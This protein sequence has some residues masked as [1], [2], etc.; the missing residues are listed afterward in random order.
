MQV[1][2][3]EGKAKREE[4]RMCSYRCDR[5]T[6]GQII[7][8]IT[9]SSPSPNSGANHQ[10]TQPAAQPELLVPEATSESTSNTEGGR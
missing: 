3:G 5:L 1:I 10:P 2:G 9:Y 6:G 8:Y 7:L 4:R